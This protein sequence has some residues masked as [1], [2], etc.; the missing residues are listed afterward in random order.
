MLLL[1]ILDAIIAIFSLRCLFT[2]SHLQIFHQRMTFLIGPD[3]QGL[4]F[5]SGDEVLCQDECYDF[6]SAVFGPGVVYD[7]P[8]EETTGPVS[9]NGQWIENRP[10]EE[11]HG[12]N[13]GRDPA[14][15]Q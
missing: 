10:H 4:F 8:P 6:M 7:A 2:F 15:S 3:A 9:N 5:R 13:S 1:T 11:I 14:I 12:Q